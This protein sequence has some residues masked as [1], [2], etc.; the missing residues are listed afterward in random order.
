MGGLTLALALRD[1]HV[2]GVSSAID[3][4]V[5]SLDDGRPVV[6]NEPCFCL[7]RVC[8][9]GWRRVSTMG[10]VRT[11]ACGWW[12]IML[13]VSI[14]CVCWG[15]VSQGHVEADDGFDAL[16]DISQALVLCAQDVDLGEQIG[17]G[18]VAVL[19]SK[20]FYGALELGNV[21][22]GLFAQRALGLTVNGALSLAALFFAQA[23]GA[24][25][26]LDDGGDGWLGRGAVSRSVAD[27]GDGDG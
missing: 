22:P 10:S 5:G 2:H 21:C 11:G 1:V 24:A 6:S 17:S 9:S 7:S 12:R 26:P 25:L 15:R 16:D 3:E 18:A 27:H 20:D 23:R 8:S 14:G 13:A 4:G 19:V